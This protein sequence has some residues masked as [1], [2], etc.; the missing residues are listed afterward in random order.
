MSVCN[1]IWKNDGKTME[2]LMEY[3]RFDYNDLYYRLVNLILDDCVDISEKHQKELETLCK[4][5]FKEID[6]RK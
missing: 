5:I 4:N 1:L 6:E 3:S 2:K